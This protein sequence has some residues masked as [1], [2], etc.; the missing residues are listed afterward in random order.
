MKY[1]EL[2]KG[3]YA[4][5]DNEDYWYLSKFKWC[6]VKHNKHWYAARAIGPKGKQKIIFMHRWILN[7]PPDLQVDHKNGDGLD[8]RKNNLRLATHSQNG[9]N[10]EWPL[11][12]RSGFKGVHWC[13]RDKVFVARIRYKGVRYHVGTFDTAERAA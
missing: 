11:N 10:R 13:N 5:V 7:A 6:A 8:N 1:I 2:T 3:K 12:N 9:C 4:I